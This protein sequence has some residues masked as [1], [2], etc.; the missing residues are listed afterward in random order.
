M[1]IK[2][3]DIISK[4]GEKRVRD[5][6]FEC[7]AKGRRVS[8]T[9]SV[10]SCYANGEITLVTPPTAQN[11]LATI[12]CKNCGCSVDYNLAALGILTKEHSDR[13]D[14]GESITVEK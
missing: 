6:C 12:V 3:D 5:D 7:G 1:N 10:Q 14:A 8:T 13:L 9:I 11:F 4:L 2:I